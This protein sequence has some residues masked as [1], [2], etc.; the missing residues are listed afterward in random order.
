MLE[1]LLISFVFW[2]YFLRYSCIA[3]MPTLF[4]Y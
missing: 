4:T 3:Y 1:L 2:C